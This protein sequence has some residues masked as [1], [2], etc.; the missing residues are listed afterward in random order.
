MINKLEH[1]FG[2]NL[3]ESVKSRF[4]AK[5]LPCEWLW[6]IYEDL[7]INKRLGSSW[8]LEN[9]TCQVRTTWKKRPTDRAIQMPTRISWL[10]MKCYIAVD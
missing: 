5:E 10:S 4:R 1:D 6:P 3:C 9:L 8:V 2:F 7:G